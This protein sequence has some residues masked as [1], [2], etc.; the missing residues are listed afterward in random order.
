[1]KNNIIPLPKKIAI[2]LFSSNEK[3]TKKQI[4]LLSPLELNY[5][6]E[7]WFRH[8]RN[9]GEYSGFSQMVNDA[10]DDTDSEFMVFFNP[11]TKPSVTLVNEIINHLCSGFAL[12]AP[13]SFG[14]FGV[15][16]ELFRTIGMFD[17]RFV[18]GEF[19]DNDF[20]L[21]L[22]LADL[23]FYH[24]FDT[25]VYDGEI[26]SI[27]PLKRGSSKSMFDLKW[28]ISP[29]LSSASQ[30]MF[31]H[32]NIPYKW[33][34]NPKYNDHKTISKKHSLNNT[35]ISNSWLPNSH[36]FKGSELF[37]QKF[38]M[39]CT[40][41]VIMGTKFPE[42][43]LSNYAI[44]INYNKEGNV[45]F[46]VKG[47]KYVFFN[48]VLNHSSTTEDLINWNVQS[49]NWKRINLKELKRYKYLPCN[50]IQLR[51]YFQGNLIYT[52]FFSLDI[53]W[54]YKDTFKLY[55]IIKPLY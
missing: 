41:E 9:P 43:E 32:P 8:Q 29:S 22:N 16:K 24:H 26:P 48:F 34:L 30:V 47:D 42:S 10:I 4:Q 7:W 6:I 23:A 18:G 49:N 38:F 35:L 1:M 54:E 50:E 52:N 21:R 17:E 51:I 28:D 15:T 31:T 39:G 40:K 11:K 53:D 2:C 27:R 45:K 44:T 12:S 19:E 3:T 36:S 5:E 20:L 33:V 25:D 37:C 55:S 13:V 14:G 46:D